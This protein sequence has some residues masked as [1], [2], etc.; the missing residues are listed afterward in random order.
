MTQAGGL[1]NVVGPYTEVANPDRLVRDPLV[2]VVMI[3]YNHEPYIAQAIEGVVSQ[4]TDFP[5][6]LIIGEDCSTDRTREIVL[7]FQ[8]RYPEIIRVL[9]SGKNVGM[10]TNG[11]RTI[12]AARGEY[13]AICEG[14]DW[15]HRRDK[16]QLQIRA[17]RADNSLV[18]IGG[19]VR[20]ISAQ[21]QVIGSEKQNKCAQPPLRIEYQ[22]LIL[23]TLI[24]YPC[25][26]VARTDAVRRTFLG[27]TLCSDHTQLMG[28]IPLF[29]E[30][31]QLGKMVYLRETL[32][33]YRHSLN[34]ATRQSDPLQVWRHEI[35]SLV[36][37]LRAL[38]RYPLPGDASRTSSL[39]A[40][41]MRQIILRA[42]WVGDGIVARNQLRRLKGLAGK[43]GWKE[44]ACVV[45]AFIPLPRR[46][47]KLGLTKITPYLRKITP[48][49][50]RMGLNP[51][52]YF[53]GAGL[54]PLSIK[55]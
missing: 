10:Q 46:S 27:D 50:E 47:L 41:F 7:E 19:E 52:K 29:L 2:S 44:I 8:R 39:K 13:M 18:Y 5:I 33:S 12:L 45:L 36:V 51:R 20:H 15:W 16:L 32:A 9:F 6:E 38:E 23:G 14:D 22:D 37:R 24:H 42:A 31:S 48:H 49:L 35:S 25:T 17:F 26:V 53:A 55:E 34:S 1:E 30:L 54:G 40:Q 28:D 4:E 21:G 11:T 3:T 43:A